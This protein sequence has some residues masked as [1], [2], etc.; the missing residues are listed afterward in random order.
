[1]CFFTNTMTELHIILQD[2]IT[3]MYWEEV[4]AKSDYDPAKDASIKFQSI[5]I[6]FSNV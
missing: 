2:D 6:G 4:R 1:M 5:N 3:R